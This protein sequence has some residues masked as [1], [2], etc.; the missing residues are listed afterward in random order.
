MT[1][2]QGDEYAIYINLTDEEGNSIVEYLSECLV[3]M[4]TET[5]SGE[6][7]TIEYDQETDSLFFILTESQTF[8]MIG[9]VP[10]QLRAIF[11][12][13]IFGVPLEPVFVLPSINKTEVHH[14]D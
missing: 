2:M 9:V 5:W 4:G 13:D 1:I 3:T 11:G 6:T 7:G 8:N 12:D 14:E 10:F